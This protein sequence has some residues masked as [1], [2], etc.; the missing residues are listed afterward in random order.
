MSVLSSNPRCPGCGGMCNPLEGG[1]GYCSMCFGTG[2]SYLYISVKDV[3]H[4]HRSVL[5]EGGLPVIDLVIVCD[6]HLLHWS[7]SGEVTRL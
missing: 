4:M 2:R 1:S 3:Q 5:L 7:R 6:D